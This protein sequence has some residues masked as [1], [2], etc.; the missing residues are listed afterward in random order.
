MKINEGRSQEIY[1]SRV[2]EDVLKPNGWDITFVNNV[3]QLGIIFDGR[4]IWTLYIERNVTKALRMYLRT[5]S[6]FQSECLST[7]TKFTIYKALIKSVRTH[8]SPT[9]EY[10]ALTS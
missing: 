7:D 2:P 6:L 1:F 4:I 3:T 8:A 9:W 5:Y 10:A